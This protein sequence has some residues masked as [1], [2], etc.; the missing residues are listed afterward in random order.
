MPTPSEGSSYLWGDLM[1]CPGADLVQ[2]RLFPDCEVSAAANWI[3]GL[4]GEDGRRDTGT[5]RL[6]VM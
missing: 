1:P 4:D 3:Q 6:V 5:R 2:D